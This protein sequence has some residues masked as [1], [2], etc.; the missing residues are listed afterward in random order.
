[1]AQKPHESAPERDEIY[2][3]G[4]LVPA[5]F[6]QLIGTNIKVLL[7]EEGYLPASLDGRVACY[8]PVRLNWQQMQQKNERQV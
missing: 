1:M 2:L 6:Y 5:G 8:E 4:H 3:A 7:K